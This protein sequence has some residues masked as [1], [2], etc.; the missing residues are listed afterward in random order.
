MGELSGG[1]RKKRGIVNES[2]GL[3]LV[4]RPYLAGLPLLGPPLCLYNPTAAM[5][6]LQKSAHI[7]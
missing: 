5:C 6:D 4:L 7:F 2:H 3:R 1:E